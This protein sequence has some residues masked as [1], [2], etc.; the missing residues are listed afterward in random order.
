MKYIILFIANWIVFLLLVD[1]KKLK[2]NV[3]S[4]I[5]AILMVFLVDY[6]NIVLKNLY[7]LNDPVIPLFGSSFFFVFGPVF[8]ISILTAQYHPKSN[9][10][11]V[12]Y[13]LVIATLYSLTELLLLK[14]GAL[15]YVDWSFFDSLL[16]NYPTIIVLSWFYMTVLK[17]V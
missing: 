15:V 2:I 3:F 8:T 9:K 11:I 10:L 13:V 14:S 1:F 7:Y 4:S 12:L 16:I 6:R 17:R 5:L